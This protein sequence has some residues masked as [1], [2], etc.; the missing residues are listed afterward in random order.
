M[1]CLEKIK[2]RNRIACINHAMK[3]ILEAGSKHHAA[4]YGRDSLEFKWCRIEH[5]GVWA[6]GG[7]CKDERPVLLW[8]RL[9]TPLPEDSEEGWYC[10]IGPRPVFSNEA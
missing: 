1:H 8:V 6:W 4:C 9:C 7:P 2:E 3:D 5:A 10:Y